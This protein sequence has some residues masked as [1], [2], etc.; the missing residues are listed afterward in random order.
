MRQLRH[1]YPDLWALLMKW[2]TDS[3]VTFH[4]DGHTVHDFDRRF[5]AE[6]GGFIKSGDRFR[7]ADLDMQQY[8]IYHYF[9]EDGTYKG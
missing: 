2:D 4:A 3:P 7:W 9:N 6:D 1:K 8:N 5:E